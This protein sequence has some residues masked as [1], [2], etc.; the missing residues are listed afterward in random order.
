[1][2]EKLFNYNLDDIL[3]LYNDIIEEKCKSAM[4]RNQEDYNN[5][6]YSIQGLQ[7]SY[8][9]LYHLNLHLNNRIFYEQQ[10]NQ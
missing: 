1:M 4:I 10:R 7:A 2:V 9:A 6:M 3:K 8:A 5:F